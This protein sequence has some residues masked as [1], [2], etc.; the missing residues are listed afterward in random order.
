MTQFIDVTDGY[1]TFLRALH[2]LEAQRHSHRVHEIRNFHIQH[3]HSND[4]HFQFPPPLL[5]TKIVQ[6]LNDEV[7]CV[8]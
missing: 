2:D 1:E 6:L 5:R 4:R 8:W 3:L 7:W